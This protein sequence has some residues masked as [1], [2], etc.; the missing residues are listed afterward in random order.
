MFFFK[1]VTMGDDAAAGTD[2]KKIVRSFEKATQQK[3]KKLM[4]NL[5]PLP[6]KLY[7]EILLSSLIKRH[8]V[9]SNWNMKLRQFLLS[10][11]MMLLML[12]LI[13]QQLSQRGLLLP[14]SKRNFCMLSLKRLR[15]IPIQMRHTIA[16]HTIHHVFFLF[17][18][19]IMLLYP[20]R[21]FYFSA[22]MLG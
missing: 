15:H 14:C 19:Q 1:A 17:P 4:E 7:V 18:R 8:V 11:A 6:T 16:M 9:S 12:H 2:D 5:L 21:T 13:A 20:I 10:V 3:G 22:A